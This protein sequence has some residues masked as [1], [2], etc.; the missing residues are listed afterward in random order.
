MSK[1]CGLDFGT[2]NSTLATV[3]GARPTL[4]PLEGDSPTLPSAVFYDEARPSSRRPAGIS[5]GRKATDLYLDGQDGRLMRSIK[6]LL[7]TDLIDASTP[8]SGRR[9]SFKAVI[10]DFLTEIKSRAEQQLGEE[11]TSVV[12]GRPV[13]FVNDDEQ[14][15]LVAQA[16][17]EEILHAIG[18]KHVEFQYEPIAAGQYFASETSKQSLCLVVDIGGGTSDFSI[19]NINTSHKS[20][21]RIQ[22]DVIAN[23]GIRLGGT[24]F[25]QTL[26]FHHVMPLLGLGAP[27][28]NKALDAPRWIYSYLS[29]WSKINLMNNPKIMRDIDWTIRQGGG[30][31]RFDR[32]DK[33]IH[34]SRGHHVAASVEEAKIA[35]STD[36]FTEI[37]LTYVEEKLS[38]EL[39]GR[40]LSVSLE[41]AIAKIN[42]AIGACLDQAGL[43]RAGINTVILTG[44]STEMP[45]LQNTI[46]DM[47]PHAEICTCDTFGAVGLG[48]AIE[49]SSLFANSSTA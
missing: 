46:T 23:A 45:I 28:S 48:L 3:G 26:S 42:D 8:L 36:D 10:A 19:I 16:T 25:D 22:G 41:E 27:L 44:G 34:S 12:Q 35:L 6:S 14:A 18:F 33:V 21:G 15:N 32:L 38:V 17:L 31:V 30:D 13:N 49:A 40:T 4:I 1:F 7:G 24:N 43:P 5:Y 9:V 37:D 2:S 11:I 47:F 20:N 29:T 39:S